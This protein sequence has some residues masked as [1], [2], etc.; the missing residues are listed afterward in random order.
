[1]AAELRPPISPH[2]SGLKVVLFAFLHLLEVLELCL[3]RIDRSRRGLA[4]TRP[5]PPACRR[6]RRARTRIVVYGSLLGRD[7]FRLC[8]YGC[9]AALA[10]PVFG[11]RRPKQRGR[12]RT[13]PPC[14][15]Q[16]RRGRFRAVESRF[17]AW[18]GRSHRGEHDGTLGSP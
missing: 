3:G 12:R 17:L 5:S 7:L 13:A 16:R 1:M 2:R 8:S 11:R 6:R 18:I 15:H 9:V 14:R 10:P 4:G